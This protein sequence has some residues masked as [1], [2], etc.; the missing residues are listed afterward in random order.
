MSDLHRLITDL[1]RVAAVCNKFAHPDLQAAA[2]NLLVTAIDAPPRPER[3]PYTRPAPAHRADD[4]TAL[5][6][7]VTDY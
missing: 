3:L 5:I 7:A 4:A 1:E 6:P 2:F